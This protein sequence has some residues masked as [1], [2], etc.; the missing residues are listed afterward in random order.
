MATIQSTQCS[1]RD[2]RS[3]WECQ[4]ADESTVQRHWPNIVE[5]MERVPHTLPN[6]T[7]ETLFEMAM[8]RLVQ[9]WLVGPPDKITLVIITQVS[10][11]PNARTL[12]VIWGAGEHSLAS[13]P[14]VDAMLE[15]FGRA[16][17]CNR[18]DVPWARLGW[19]KIMA[20]YGFKKMAVV[21]SKPIHPRKDS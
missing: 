20:P 15:N 13:G 4:L 18:L 7:P 12:D 10:T 16:C 8:N 3:G 1:G 2:L 6:H 17:G 21:L 11:F 14:I 9:V 19:E 5:M